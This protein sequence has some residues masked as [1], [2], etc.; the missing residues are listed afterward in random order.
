MSQEDMIKVRRMKRLDE[1][2]RELE[3]FAIVHKTRD[4]NGNNIL[5]TSASMPNFRGSNLSLVSQ[6]GIGRLSNHALYFDQQI[7][8]LRKSTQFFRARQGH[9]RNKLHDTE[10]KGE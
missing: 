7:T 10:T 9:S 1:L 6:D 8:R 4:V 5:V 3:E 2:K